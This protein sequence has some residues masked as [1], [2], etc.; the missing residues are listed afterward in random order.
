M[1]RSSPFP[2][3]PDLS[4]EFD[5]RYDRDLEHADREVHRRTVRRA[6]DPRGTVKQR[7]AP[8]PTVREWVATMADEH[9]STDDALAILRNGGL[10]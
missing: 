1:P 2:G 5:A 8:D 7:F 10:L 9:T 4:A 3:E 6:L